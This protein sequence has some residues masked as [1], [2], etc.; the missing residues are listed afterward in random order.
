MQPIYGLTAGLTNKTVTKYVR[1]LLENQALE[2]EY[3]PLDVRER[4]RLA[5][6]NFAIQNIHFPK[7]RDSLIARVPFG[8]R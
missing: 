2:G 4:Y 7:D 8:V 6:Y 5:D 1:L 3:L